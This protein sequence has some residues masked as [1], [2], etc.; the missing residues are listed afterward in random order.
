M[1]VD[2]YYGNKKIEYKDVLYR[3]NK[4]YLRYL[5][6]IKENTLSA[7]RKWQCQNHAAFWQ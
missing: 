2:F 1:I 4:S 7:Y 6:S 3:V 5:S